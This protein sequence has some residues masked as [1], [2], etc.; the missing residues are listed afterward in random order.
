[1]STGSIA[2]IGAGSG[3]QGASAAL[4]ARSAPASAS[5]TRPVLRSAWFTAL[6][7]V[8]AQ[9]RVPERVDH[10]QGQPLGDERV[11][12]AARADEPHAP[13]AAQLRDQA[14]AREEPGV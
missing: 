8:R 7:Y 3:S 2:Y 14:L 6:L 12:L 1:M 13:R 5:S 11:D 9:A 10:A 4:A